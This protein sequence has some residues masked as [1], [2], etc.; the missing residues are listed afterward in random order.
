M[1]RYCVKYDNAKVFVCHCT[2]CILKDLKKKYV[3]GDK[4]FVDRPIANPSIG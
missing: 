4:Q 3:V 2:M 1:R